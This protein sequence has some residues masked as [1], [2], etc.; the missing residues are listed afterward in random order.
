MGEKENSVIN[1]ELIDGLKQFAPG[2]SVQRVKCFECK[3]ADG[4]YCNLFRKDRIRIMS[5]DKIALQRCPKF[6][7]KSGDKNG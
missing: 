5:E 6:E 3:H 1:K 4:R 2:S 7:P